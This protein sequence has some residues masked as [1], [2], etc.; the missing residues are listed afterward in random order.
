[1]YYIEVSKVW[2]GTVK[3]TTLSQPIT[4]DNHSTNRIKRQVG[5]IDKIFDNAIRVIAK[6]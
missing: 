3:Q 2:R 5:H 1:M 6:G 4:S